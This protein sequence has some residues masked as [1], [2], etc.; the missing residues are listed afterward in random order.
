MTHLNKA[1]FLQTKFVLKSLKTVQYLNKLF[2][3]K[4]SFHIGYVKE[5][6]SSADKFFSLVILSYLLHY[7]IT[8]FNDFLRP[9][10]FMTFSGV[11]G[12]V[13]INPAIEH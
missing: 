5:R 10:S 8:V 9:F 6:R 4:Q 7:C 1:E 11:H 3:A 2:K 13:Y 12:R